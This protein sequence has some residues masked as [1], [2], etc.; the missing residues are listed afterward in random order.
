MRHIMERYRYLVFFKNNNGLRIP[1]QL[2][3]SIQADVK[4]YWVAGPIFTCNL[5]GKYLTAAE[6]AY[7]YKIEDGFIVGTWDP[8]LES[9]A[10]Q[11]PKCDNE[12][13]TNLVDGE[14]YTITSGK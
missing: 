13:F 9:Y 5:C 3:M 4:P 6:F 8:P 12:F 11:C 14:E 10:L 7:G 1:P 2:N